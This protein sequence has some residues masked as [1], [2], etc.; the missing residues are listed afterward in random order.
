[1]KLRVHGPSRQAES[2]PAHLD[3]ASSFYESDCQGQFSSLLIAFSSSPLQ[4]A[5]S[6]PKRT[7]ESASGWADQS[8]AAEPS[9]VSSS[10]LCETLRASWRS[11]QGCR[12]WFYL[13]LTP[14][15]APPWSNACS[16][17]P[18]GP[19]V[20]RVPRRDWLPGRRS[21][22]RLSSEPSSRMLADDRASHPHSRRLGPSRYVACIVSF[23]GSQS[24][25]FF[26]SRSATEASFRARVSLAISSRTPPATQRS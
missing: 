13:R 11:P 18:E 10:I 22:M 15:C 6:V 7:I 3:R 17:H 4:S 5:P 2:A 1:M 14:A 23:V 9:S 26:H 8:F 19:M 12:P 25:P 21:W 24:S 16:G 20:R